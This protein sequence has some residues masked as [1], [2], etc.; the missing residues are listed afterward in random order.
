MQYPLDLETGFGEAL[1]F[2]GTAF[3]AGFLGEGVFFEAAGLF[4]DFEE[5]CDAEGFLDG[6]SAKVFDSF[7][8]LGML[9]FF[10]SIDSL[11]LEAE[12]LSAKLSDSLS[13]KT[14]LSKLIC[15]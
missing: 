11:L 15:S 4:A 13:F 2:S 3:K 6:L 10:S 1:G 12:A 5:F 7:L 9:G 8:T 14:F